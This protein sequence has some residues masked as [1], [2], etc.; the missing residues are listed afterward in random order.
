M[1]YIPT[2]NRYCNHVTD[3]TGL[4][5]HL[6]GWLANRPLLGSYLVCR[7]SVAVVVVSL[8]SC[9][10][11]DLKQEKE[12]MNQYVPG[13]YSGWKLSDSSVAYDRESIFDYINGAG[14]VYRSYSFQ[15]V[16]VFHYQSDGHPDILAELFDMGSDGDAYGVFS[17]ARENEQAGIG[18]AYEYRGGLLCFWQDRFYVCL[19]TPKLTTESK[20]ALFS[21]ARKIDSLL[22][23]SGKKPDLVD[24]LPPQDLVLS[25]VRYFHTHPSLNYHYFLA[26]ENLLNLSSRTHAVLGRYRP[27]EMQLLCVR[28]R[29]TGQADEAYRSFVAGYVPEL[30]PSGT[31]LLEQGKWVAADREGEYMIVVL[32]A[33]TEA[34]ADKLMRTMKKRLS[35]VKSK[36]R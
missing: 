10:K 11:H 17:Y 13:S 27:A 25:G 32:D 14:E 12:V 24:M 36:G 16:S 20:E 4:L 8:V 6:S 33:S 26:E 21:I 30:G 23:T 34:D 9:G 31:A 2:A 35:T 29:T 3:L 1:L 18:Q 7:L 15:Q 19:S 28:Y 22:P 5:T